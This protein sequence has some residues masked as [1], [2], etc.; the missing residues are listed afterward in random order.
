M[1][2]TRASRTA[3][4]L[5]L[6]AALLLAHRAAAG[7]QD[8]SGVMRNPSPLRIS[9]EIVQVDATVIDDKGKPVRD[10]E[11]ADFE[12]L[13][14][15]RPQ[16][17]SAFQ[18][19]SGGGTAGTLGPVGAKPADSPLLPTP[20][21]RGAVR[22]TMAIVVDDL[23]LSFESI[24]RVRTALRRFID[25][26]MQPGD[27]VAILRTGAGMGALQQFTTDKRLLHA[28]AD[29]VQWNRVA[30]VTA[31]AAT[32]TDAQVD[33]LQK[34][35]F[36]KGTLGAVLYVLRGVSQLPGRKSLLLLS[37]GFRLTDV[38][39]VQSVADLAN[40]AGVVVHGIDLRGL[41][42]DAPSAAEGGTATPG[43][44]VARSRNERTAGETGPDRL[45]SETGGL[46]I[47]NVND[48]AAG[49][50]RVLDE[51]QDFYLLGYV[52]EGTT[53]AA[54]NPKYHAITV[55]VNRPGLR[56]RSRKGFFGRT[57]P[58]A[59]LSADRMLA[60]VTSPFAGGDIR[61]R[62]SSFFGRS[63]D[64]GTVVQSMMHVDP[65]GLTFTADAEGTRTAQIEVLA[66]T[67][68]ENG[69]VADQ[70]RRRYTVRFTPDRFAVAL[71]HGFVY[72]LRLP[73]KRPGPYQLRIALRDASTDRIG[74]ANQFVDVPDLTKRQLTL[75]GLFIQGLGVGGTSDGAVEAGD[76]NSTIA[77]RRFRRGIQAAYT[78]YAYNVAKDSSGKPQV[79][80]EMRLFRDGVEVLRVGAQPAAASLDPSEV[81]IAGLLP[82]ALSMTPGNYV[83][84][85]AVTDRLA[86]KNRRATQLIDF[87]VIE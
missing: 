29:R 4:A 1:P 73:V 20:A 21:T 71:Q 72:N 54:R 83:L 44:T 49:V 43:Q 13:Q 45:T 7:A 85:I 8:A 35:S 9:V 80:S 23:A 58:P 59:G 12:V 30:S 27:L 46:F 78:C 65:H 76:P 75:S 33:E 28:A 41:A 74:S 64:G 67:F 60:A 5:A 18:Y 40:R 16:K 56:V 38:S 32:E 79:E 86:R 34:E 10:L 55:R 42:A 53:F 2:S 26:Q 25:T 39:M 69:M 14:D 61:L 82:I 22:R 36:T 31:F 62:L 81:A 52:P 77:V 15:G 57:D 6:S 37:D 3:A 48:I 11:A 84:E 87:E 51:D 47:R 24:G 50:Q 63:R 66:M 19:V 70:L 68:G 17:I